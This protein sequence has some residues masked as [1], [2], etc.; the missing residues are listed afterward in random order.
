[1]VGVWSVSVFVLI[2][3]LSEWRRLMRHNSTC[4]QVISSGDRLLA[5]WNGYGGYPTEPASRDSTHLRRMHMRSG[6]VRKHGIRLKLHHRP[7]QVLS[8]LLERPGTWGTREELRQR[9]WPAETFVDFDTGLNSAVKKLRD[10]LCDS[11]EQPR[12]I[13]TLPRRG[14]RFIAQVENGDFV[15]RS[16]ADR[17][18][19]CCSLCGQ[20]RVKQMRRGLGR[21]GRRLEKST[22]GQ[23]GL[24]GHVSGLF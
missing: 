8:L 16:S 3:Q 20:I 9:L 2:V 19:R 4:P 22:S 24:R 5:I 13:E 1:M 7:F 14:Y 15:H 6:E 11:A 12:Y 17:F 21:N 10:A 18:A 23:P